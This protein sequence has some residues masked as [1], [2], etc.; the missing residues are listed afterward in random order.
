[1]FPVQDFLNTIG[2][3][4]GADVA[5]LAAPTTFVALHL[6]K[7]PFTPGP[8]LD[9]G[10]LVEADFDGYAALHAASAATQV[11]FDPATGNQIV[12]VREPAGGWHWASSGVTNLPMTIYGAYLTSSDGTDLIA[13]DLF[14]EPIVMTGTGQGVDWDQVRMTIAG[15]LIS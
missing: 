15:V 13:T 2:T 12:Q 8:G 3:L 11:F 10:D 1:M 9:I 7:A 4:L 5:W 6:A 14:A